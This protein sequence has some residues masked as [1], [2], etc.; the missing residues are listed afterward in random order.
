MAP[1]EEA[2]PP[3]LAEADVPRVQADACARVERAGLLHRPGRRTTFP[4]DAVPRV[5]PAAEW[6]G[7][8]AGLAQRVTAL[9]AFV[10]DAYGPRRI[11]QAGVVPARVI[12]TAEHYE[13]AMRGVEPPGGLSATGTGEFFIREAVAHEISAVM[14]YTDL[15][16]AG[17]A[18][19]GIEKVED[20]GGDGGVI[21]LDASGN[22]AMPFNTEGM[23]RGYVTRSGEVVT[24]I[25][26][27]E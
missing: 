24:K 20:L 22:L 2:T 7:L 16:I 21:A 1:Y 12:D 3:G 4:L 19:R 10:A 17:A 14:E 9:S 6:D 11:V 18:R 8:E 26:G 27:D 25:Y 13:P 5:L 23:Y 15:E